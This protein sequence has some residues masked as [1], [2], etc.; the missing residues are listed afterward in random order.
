MSEL[1]SPQIGMFFRL[2]VVVRIAQRWGFQAAFVVMN[3]S[4]LVTKLFTP[5]PPYSNDG[6]TVNGKAEE[7]HGAESGLCRSCCDI[8]EVTPSYCRTAFHPAE[9]DVA[10]PR[11]AEERYRQQRSVTVYGKGNAIDPYC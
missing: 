5:V 9:D 8:Y 2:V 4:S 10:A 3:Y 7:L 1:V 11:P 6:F